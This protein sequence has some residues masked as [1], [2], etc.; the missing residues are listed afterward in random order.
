MLPGWLFLV[1]AQSVLPV[2][3]ERVQGKRV[4][5]SGGS[6]LNL[7]IEELWGMLQKKDFSLINVHIPYEGELPRTDAFIPY[8]EVGK[9]LDKLPKSKDAKIV[10]YCISGRM[11]AIAAETL[12]GLGYRNVWNLRQG[13][14]E[15]RQKSLPLLDKR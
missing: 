9:H 14:R 15:W 6:Y 8:D 5:V 1:G 3:G 12:V 2:P 13:M 11:S 10:L 7:E 4:E